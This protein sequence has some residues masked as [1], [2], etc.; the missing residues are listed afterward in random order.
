MIRQLLPACVAVVE[1]FR[2]VIGEAV[3]PGEEDLVANATESRRREFI[4]TRRC[5]REALAKLGYKPLPIRSGPKR[6]PQWPA[7]VVGS[8]AHTT[9]YRV[10]AVASQH[11]IASIGVDAEQHERLP[12]GVEEFVTA[13]GEAQML[14]SLSKTFPAIHWSRLL[15]SVKE[16]V[17][18]AWYP[19]TGRWLGFEHVQ[20]TINPQG[21]FSAT[22]LADGT[23][24]DN[25]T[26]LTEVR[27]GF[28]LERGLIATA[29]TVPW[30]L[31]SH[32]KRNDHG[33]A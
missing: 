31:S 8:I 28:V 25:G 16:S 15:F 13:P 20:V 10:A 7:G 32:S 5:A 23:R 1:A 24:T 29:V 21:T 14:A 6:E 30:R 2:D 9:G 3:F 11:F 17:Y 19:L 18:K 22:L 33:A 26:S 12:D 4:T 27:G